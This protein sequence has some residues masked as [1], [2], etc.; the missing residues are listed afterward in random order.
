MLTRI[1][2]TYCPLTAALCTPLTT[3]E[4]TALKH[5]IVPHSPERREFLNAGQGVGSWPVA[6][7]GSIG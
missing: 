1:G 3:D 6:V 5:A 2:V 4:L 7:H